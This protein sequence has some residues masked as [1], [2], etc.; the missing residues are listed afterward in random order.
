MYNLPQVINAAQ[1][2]KFQIQKAIIRK[3]QLLPQRYFRAV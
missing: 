1:A 3:A 2:N